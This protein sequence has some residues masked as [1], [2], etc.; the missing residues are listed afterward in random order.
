MTDNIEM[1]KYTP[2][3]IDQSCNSLIVRYWAKINLTDQIN[4]VALVLPELYQ[5][6]IEVDPVSTVKI[7]YIRDILPALDLPTK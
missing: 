7:S 1:R 5:D 3:E 4:L 2:E 6:Y